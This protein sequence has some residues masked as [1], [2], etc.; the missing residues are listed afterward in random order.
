[1]EVGLPRLQYFGWLCSHCLLKWRSQ[2]DSHHKAESSLQHF[3]TY[4][5]AILLRYYFADVASDSNTS[6]VPNT[7]NTL[8][9]VRVEGYDGDVLK[10]TLNLD[11][12]DFIWNHPTVNQPSS[13]NKGQKGAI[14]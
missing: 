2:R 9:K 5:S 12:L 11:D 1:M 14:I 8:L 3:E 13:F 6:W 10:A 4:V 7:Q